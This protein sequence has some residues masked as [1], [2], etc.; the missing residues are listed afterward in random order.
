MS[1]RRHI[2]ASIT[3]MTS[4]AITALDTSTH[5]IRRKFR[6]SL[7]FLDVFNLS[8]ILQVLVEGIKLGGITASA[9]AKTAGGTWGN[10][11]LWG[12]SEDG[13]VVYLTTE[14]GDYL[15][16]EDGHYLVE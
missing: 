15:M 7:T 16:T 5:T 10:G 3:F 8:S 14:G 12:L 6:A 4:G 9:T 11:D 13:A 2:V 1:I